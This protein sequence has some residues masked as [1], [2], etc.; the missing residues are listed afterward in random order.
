[1]HKSILITHHGATLEIALHLLIAKSE[2]EIF[3]NITW[4]YITSYR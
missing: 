1:M 3:E 4:P 2:T